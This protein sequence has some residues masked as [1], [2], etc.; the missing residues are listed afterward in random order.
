MRRLKKQRAATEQ[1]IEPQALLFDM[2]ETESLESLQQKLEDE[3]PK[4]TVITR[5][6]LEDQVFE[7]ELALTVRDRY[8]ATQNEMIKQQQE[9]IRCY[10]R[11]LE[12]IEVNFLLTKDYRAVQ[13][14][15]DRA[16]QWSI[17]NRYHRG[18]YATVDRAAALELATRRLSE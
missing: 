4:R 5:K 8:A 11:F 1:V 3:K 14:L 7:L 12:N 18:D 16:C 10:E 15:I 6:N 17:A 9:K 13:E 2:P